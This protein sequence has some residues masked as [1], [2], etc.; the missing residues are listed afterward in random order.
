MVWE[1]M[2]LLVVMTTRTV[3]RG[4]IKCGQYWPGDDEQEE[5]YGDFIVVN[6]GIERFDTYVVTSLLLKNTNVSATAEHYLHVHVYA[7]FRAKCP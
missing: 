5:E 2:V 1:Q 4:R 3:E 7:P 6:N